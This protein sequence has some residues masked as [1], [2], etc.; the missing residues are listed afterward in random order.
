MMSTI[1]LWAFA[2]LFAC[3]D[4]AAILFFGGIFALAIIGM[5]HID[6]RRDVGW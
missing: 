2:N 1:S 3:G 4:V 6:R 5:V